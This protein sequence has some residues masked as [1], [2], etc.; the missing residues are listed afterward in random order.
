LSNP[1]NANGGNLCF[2]TDQEDQE[3]SLNIR[4]YKK[5]IELTDSTMKMDEHF[6]IASNI[7]QVSREFLVKGTSFR[8]VLHT[9]R[10]HLALQYTIPFK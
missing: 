7:T 3:D 1:P 8:P 4:G 10:F 9:R 6:S 5:I 2:N